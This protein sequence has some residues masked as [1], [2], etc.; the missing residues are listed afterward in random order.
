M[1]SPEVS[2]TAIAAPSRSL[3]ASAVDSTRF[4]IPIA[5]A[6]AASVDDVTAIIADA[7]T[8]GVAMVILR[9]PADDLRVAQ[10]IEDAGGRLCDTLVYYARALDRAIPEQPRPIRPADPRDIDEITAIAAD[11]FARYGG[12]YHA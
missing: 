3:S 2:E 10:A 7:S 11:A 4:G 8:S 9:S 1:E 6:N 12:H 5:R